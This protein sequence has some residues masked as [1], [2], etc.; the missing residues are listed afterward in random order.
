VDFVILDIGSIGNVIF[1]I[2]TVIFIVIAIESKNLIKSAIS[3]G[4][5]SALLAIV[6]YV[7]EAP[8]AAIF[9][10]SVCAGLVTILLLSA[11]GMLGKE[12][13]C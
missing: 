2:A 1:L 6:F 9:E 4:I 11:I 7:L 5:A 8:I 10:L 3:L 12:E 13:E